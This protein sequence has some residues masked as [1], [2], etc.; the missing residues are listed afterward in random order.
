MV[1]IM[2]IRNVASDCLSVL[3]IHNRGMVIIMV[4]TQ[5]SYLFI[6]IFN[7]HHIKHTSNNGKINIYYIIHTC[8]CPTMTIIVL[9]I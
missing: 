5:G 3:K 9:S 7:L 4:K 8:I 1:I 6:K 2:V